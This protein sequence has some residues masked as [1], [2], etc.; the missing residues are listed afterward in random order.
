[1]YDSISYIY[2]RARIQKGSGKGVRVTGGKLWHRVL[3]S[4]TGKSPAAINVLAVLVRVGNQLSRSLPQ[5][6]VEYVETQQI[7][8]NRHSPSHLKLFSTI[9]KKAFD[10]LV[11]FFSFKPKISSSIFSMYCFSFK[12]LLSS[13]AYAFCDNTRTLIRINLIK[14]IIN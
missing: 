12:I 3:Q 10:Y 14:I 2:I 8:F 1:M 4:Y 5:F 11:K 9:R 6:M 13:S 7:S